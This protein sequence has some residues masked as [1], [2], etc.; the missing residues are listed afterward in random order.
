[1]PIGTTAANTSVLGYGTTFQY[2]LDG[3]NTYTSIAQCMELQPP[4]I[5]INDVDITGLL[6]PNQA[7]QFRPGLLDGGEVA[8]KLI[9]LASVLSA[10]YNQLFNTLYWKE[11]YPD[12]T[13][14][15]ST[16]VFQ[17]YIKKFGGEIPVDNNIMCNVTIKVT[18]KPVF[19]AGS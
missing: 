5:T 17:G 6:S 13:T 4:D 1:M 8:F 10:L 12:G 11:I 14:Q 18:G 19:T 2:S 16:W 9:F 7:K 15:G 3:G